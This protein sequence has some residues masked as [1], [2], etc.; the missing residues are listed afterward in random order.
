MTEKAPFV[1]I[2]LPVY[3]GENFLTE[4]IESILAQ[5]YRDFELIISDNGSTDGTASICNAFSAQDSRVRYYRSGENQGAAWNFNRVFALARGK[6][7]KWMAHDDL[8]TPQYLEKCVRVLEDDPSLVLCS[9][10]IRQ[11]NLEGQLIQSF[12]FEHHRINSLKPE[13]RFHDIVLAWHNCY[14]IFG[15]IRASELHKTPL[16]GNYSYGDAVLLGRLGLQGRFYQLNEYAFL[17]RS[18]EGQSMVAFNKADSPLKDAKPL[19]ARLLDAHAYSVWF[20]PQKR[21]KL[22]LPHWRVLSEYV[23]SVWNAQLSLR[24]STVCF[25]V[26]GRWL[27]RF[28]GQLLQDIFGTLLGR[29]N[30]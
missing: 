12:A 30:A 19:S 1:S 7:F 6:Y 18:H 3:N 22:L 29:T 14:Y 27:F 23:K 20:D 9:T 4:A 2:G 16:M 28:R 8:I 15:L 25:Y 10:C 24:E 26:V 17:A 13:E 5:T 21:G 11:I